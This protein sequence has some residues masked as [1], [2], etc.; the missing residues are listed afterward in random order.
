MAYYWVN[1]GTTFEEV[2]QGRFLWAPQYKMVQRKGK[3]PT[4]QKEASWT[5][6]STVKKDDVIFCYADGFIIYVAT[7]LKGCIDS[8]RP[9][10]AKFGEWE[11][12][13]YRVDVK[14][15][16]LDQ[17]VALDLFRSELFERYNESCHPKILDKNASVCQNYM[18][19]IPDG[20]AVLILE[21]LGDDALHFNPSLGHSKRKLSKTT[22]QSLVNSRIGQGQFRKDLLNLW[23][24]TCAFTGVSV[25][26]LLIASHIYPW[27]LSDNDERLDPCNGL[28]LSPSIDKLFDKGYVSFSNEGHLIKGDR[29]DDKLLEQLGIDPDV[30]ISGLTY[31]HAYYLTKHRQLFKFEAEVK[32]GE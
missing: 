11:M 15:H 9:E 32:V 19:T 20:A 21:A 16:I 14:L 8:F 31:E 22:Q 26:E 28:P 2:K 13:G 1:L 6:V 18:V 29:I 17:P 27:Q 30:K 10:N 12:D 7:A 23:N 5:T 4:R 25:P 24:G 3:E